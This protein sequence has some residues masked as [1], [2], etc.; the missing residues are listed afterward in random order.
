MH[1]DVILEAVSPE[2][3]VVIKPHQV[4]QITRYGKSEESSH[5]SK[6]F[7]EGVG[8]LKGYNKQREREAEDGIGKTFDT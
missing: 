8:Y 6:Q 5:G 4:E 7:I 2:K 1:R 3:L